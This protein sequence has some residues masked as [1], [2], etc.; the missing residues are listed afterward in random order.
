MTQQTTSGYA[1]SDLQSFMGRI[2]YSY[3]DKYLL[4][5]SIRDDGS[6]RLTRKYSA[7]PSVAVGWSLSKENFMMN[8]RVFSSLKLRGSYGQ[9][10]NQGIPPYSSLPVINTSNVGYYFDGT[11]LSISTPLGSPVAN[12]LVWE[13]TLQTDFGLDAAFFNN[14]LSFSI[15]AYKKKISNLLFSY[16]TPAYLGG[17]NY[18]RNIGSIQNRGIELGISGTPIASNAGKLNWNSFFE[19]SFNDNKVLDLNGLDNVIVSGIGQPQQNISIL[20]VGKP[21]GEFTGYKFLGTWKTKEA[22][23]AAAFGNKP[24]DAKFLDVNNDNT[25]NQ[26]DYVPIGNGI[27]KFTWGFIND[28]SYG[29]FSLSFMFAGQGGSQIYSQTIAYTWGQAPG[30]RN[31]TLQEATKM[32]T[33][34][35]ETDVPA[36]STTGSFPTNSSR[37]VYS[38]NFVKLKNLSL[39]YSIPQSV[40]GSVKIQHLDVYVSGQNLFTITSYPGYDPELT[41]AQSALTQGVEMGVIPN[42]R[43]FTLGLRVGF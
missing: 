17:G 24:G 28:F 42:P 34:Q 1:S 21:L 22:S 15:D 37:F 16:Q 20:K 35:N 33:A 27:P 25:I 4:T 31:A 7:F 43:T 23:Q 39:T 12:D 13:T 30:T 14:R 6:S 2:N 10:G 36:F 41:N 18:Q 29:N 3:K 9:T 32:W 26:D 11:S 19:I 40:L 8:S 5:A 38:A